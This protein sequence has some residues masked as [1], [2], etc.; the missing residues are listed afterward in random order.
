MLNQILVKNGFMRNLL[1]VGTLKEIS[2][3]FSLGNISV[4]TDYKIQ[5]RFGN[6]Q[7]AYAAYQAI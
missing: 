2:E 4:R 1:E 3:D 6:F 7:E 5:L